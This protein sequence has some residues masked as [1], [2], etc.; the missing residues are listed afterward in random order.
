MTE[1]DYRAALNTAIE[2]YERLGEERRGI[3]DRLAQLT[4][5][6]GTLSRLLGLTPTVPLGL[7]DALR[8]I[9][10]GAGIPLSPTQARDRL[11]A[12]GFDLS[13]YSNEMAAIHTVLKRLHDAGELRC[14][15]QRGRAG[16]ALRVV[17]TWRVPPT[18]MA[19]GADEARDIRGQ[20][21]FHTDPP[22]SPR[23]G[24]QR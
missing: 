8:L 17:Y 12:M 3:D 19:I 5:T 14:A 15:A 20:G 6:I 23:K 11:R 1:T 22:A 7:T 24:K 18:V 10:R 16:A 21:T 2:E 4:Q 9:Y 13:T